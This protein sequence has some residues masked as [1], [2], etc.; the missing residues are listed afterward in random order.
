VGLGLLAGQWLD[1]QAHTGILF[2]LMGVFAGLA[3]GIMSIVALYRATLRASELEWRGKSRPEVTTTR[4]N[5]ASLVD[6]DAD[7]PSGS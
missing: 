3:V 1:G 2:T 4:R 6:H 5:N 7:R